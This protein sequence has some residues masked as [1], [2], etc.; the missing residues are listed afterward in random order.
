LSKTSFGVKPSDV[1]VT[2]RLEPAEDKVNI[3]RVGVFSKEDLLLFS[4][5]GVAMVYT[6]KKLYDQHYFPA[7][8]RPMDFPDCRLPCSW[9]LRVMTENT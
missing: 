9:H 8:S 4:T 5:T 3:P 6:S 2:P 7:G 1:L